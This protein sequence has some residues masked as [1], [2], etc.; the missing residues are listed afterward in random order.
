MR[1]NGFNVFFYFVVLYCVDS[2]VHKR[3]CVVVVHKRS[4]VVW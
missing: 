3:S 4:C 2:V 1:E